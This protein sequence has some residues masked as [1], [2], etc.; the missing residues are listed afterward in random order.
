MIRAQ[1]N[2]NT[3]TYILPCGTQGKLIETIEADGRIHIQSIEGEKEVTLTFDQDNKELLID[4]SKISVT[5]T[6]RFV[7]SQDISEL[8]FSQW[9]FWSQSTPDIH[10]ETQIRWLTAGIVVA[11]VTMVLN[12]LIGF[13]IATAMAVIQFYANYHTTGTVLHAIRRMYVGH[14]SIRRVDAF[15]GCENRLPGC[16]I[17]TTTSYMFE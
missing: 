4:E 7:L 11:A 12:P 3:L 13:G 17:A 16:H 10:F 1:L 9:R 15:F 2:G 5:S 14:V 8:S 6:E